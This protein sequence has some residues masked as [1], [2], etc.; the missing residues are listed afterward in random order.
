MK[1]YTKAGDEGETQLLG[2]AKVPKNHLRISAYGTV[3]ELN[4]FVGLLRD[5]ASVDEFLPVLAAIQDRLFTIGSYLATDPDQSQFPLPKFS[6]EDITVLEESIDAMEAD[7]PPLKNFVLPGGHPAN[8]AAHICRTV[9]RRAEREVVMLRE[10]AEV[11][12]TI[13]GYLNRLSD[14]FFVLSR[15]LIYK[16]NA[17]EV[18]WKPRQ[19]T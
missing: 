10:N 3:D 4:A 5:Q 16:N 12:P 15:I 17:E 11:N 9:C 7:L 14:W 19:G 18:V 1:I 8:S 2:G 6:E 13:I